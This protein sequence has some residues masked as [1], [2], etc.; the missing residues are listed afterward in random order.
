MPTQN[1]FWVNPSVW[2]QAV[3]KILQAVGKKE[4]DFNSWQRVIHQ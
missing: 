3:P 1:T 4:V 2:H